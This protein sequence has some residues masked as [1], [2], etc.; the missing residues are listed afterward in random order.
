MSGS[1]WDLNCLLFS[2]LFFFPFLVLRNFSLMSVA[3]PHPWQHLITSTPNLFDCDNTRHAFFCSGIE[4]ILIVSYSGIL[5]KAVSHLCVWRETE[6]EADVATE[7]DI[8]CH[9]LTVLVSQTS[10]PRTL[11]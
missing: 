1:A 3:L 5:S 7:Q 10:L 9:I 11:G 4:S 8:S 2:F 6:S